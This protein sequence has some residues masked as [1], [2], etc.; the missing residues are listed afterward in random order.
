MRYQV[1][2]DAVAVA[3]GQTRACAESISSQ[4]AAMMGHLTGLQESWVGSAS[5]AFASLAA[6]WRAT[7]ATIEDNLR[8]IGL[9]LDAASHT[10][11]QA[12]QTS[13]ALFAGA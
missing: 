7:Q 3:A 8:Q 13:T 10:Y 4:V 9:Q 2:S 11:S 6:Q 12:E 1:D 5:S